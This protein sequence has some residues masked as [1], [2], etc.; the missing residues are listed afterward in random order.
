MVARMRLSVAIRVHCLFCCLRR[1]RAQMAYMCLSKLLM[2]T[3][4]IV[5][6]VLRVRRLCLYFMRGTVCE[7]RPGTRKYYPPLVSHALLEVL[8][9]L[10]SCLGCE[11]VFTWFRAP[12]QYSPVGVSK[13]TI[14]WR[15][16][17]CEIR[18]SS[19]YVISFS[20]CPEDGSRSQS[21][22]CHIPS[23]SWFLMILSRVLTNTGVV[24]W[25]VTTRGLPRP[26]AG[27]I[28][29]WISSNSI[30]KQYIFERLTN[31][32]HILHSPEERCLPQLFIRLEATVVRRPPRRWHTDL[33]IIY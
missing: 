17:F 1:R 4:H 8:T 12:R 9:P 2:V 10:C 33:S 27:N 23:Y 15:L 20:D 30:F 6:T 18:E 3:F 29:S 22:Q 13:I 31:L 11:S 24:P 32:C 14:S 28:Y 16:K 19:K 7:S 5:S 26:R 21:T 25:N